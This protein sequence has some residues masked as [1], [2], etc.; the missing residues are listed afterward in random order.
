MLLSQHAWCVGHASPCSAVAL[1]WCAVG[2]LDTDHQLRR[3]KDTR[4]CS[5]NRERARVQV[6]RA[7]ARV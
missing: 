2:M 5:K 4:A 6:A 1:R 3:A 7:H